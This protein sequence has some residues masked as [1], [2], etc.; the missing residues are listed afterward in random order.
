MNRNRLVLLA[1]I[2]PASI[3]QAQPTTFG[4]FKAEDQE[5]KFQKVLNQDSVT[6]EKLAKFY[7]GQPF[8]SDVQITPTGVDFLINDVVVDLRK[9]QFRQVDLPTLIQTGKYSGKV[10]VA[11]REGRYRI[12]ITNFQVTGNAGYRQVTQKETLTAFAC[13]KSG[14]VL[15]PDWCKPNSLGLLEM[16]FTDKLQFVPKKDDW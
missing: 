11:V 12:L 9:F 4:S 8:I 6:A 5:I 1:L 7:E 10:S 3:A 2:L 13:L 16:T 14:T 15:N